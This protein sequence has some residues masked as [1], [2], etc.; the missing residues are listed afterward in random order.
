M[1]LSDKLCTTGSN[2][3][4]VFPDTVAGAVSYVFFDETGT[5]LFLAFLRHFREEVVVF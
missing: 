1:Y 5:G 4:A 3:I 2:G